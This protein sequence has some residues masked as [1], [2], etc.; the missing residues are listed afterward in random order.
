[1]CYLDA[2]HAL[3]IEN[4]PG[5][6]GI[7]LLPSGNVV[8]GATSEDQV[9]VY[10]PEGNL[11]FNVKVVSFLSSLCFSLNRSCFRSPT[12]SSSVPPTWSPSPTAGLQ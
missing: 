1:M 3:T 6:I 9:R 12:A 8:V 7:C 5:P 10:D 4:V 11:L 2:R